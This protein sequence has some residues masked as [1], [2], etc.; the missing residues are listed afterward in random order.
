MFF[1]IRRNMLYLSFLLCSFLVILILKPRFNFNTMY[2]I[3]HCC[4]WIEYGMFRYVNGWIQSVISWSQT[5]KWVPAQKRR[6]GRPRNGHPWLDGVKS[7]DWRNRNR[8]RLGCEK[9]FWC[10]IYSH[11]DDDDTSICNC[12]TW[13][14]IRKDVTTTSPSDLTTTVS[15]LWSILFIYN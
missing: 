14:L 13:F 6:R 5:F 9:R 1:S 8:R 15:F 12:C 3:A 10:W 11:A 4:L 7:E 2:A